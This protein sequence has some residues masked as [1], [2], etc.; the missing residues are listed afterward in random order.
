[1]IGC[2]NASAGRK[3]NAFQIIE[4]LES[5]PEGARKHAI[6]LSRI[7]LALGEKEKA[8]DY[9]K[10]AFDEHEIDLLTLG[11]DPR[12]TPLRHGTRFK[13]FPLRVGLPSN[14]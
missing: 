8:Y 10:L 12:L 3:E 9:F 14:Y 6:K 2:V 11:L 1:M 13:E 4:R 7:Y 5:Q